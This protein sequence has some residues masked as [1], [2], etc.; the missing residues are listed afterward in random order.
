MAFLCCK[1]LQPE[2]KTIVVKDNQWRSNILRSQEQDCQWL[3]RTKYISITKKLSF[4]F[5]YEKIFI[6][7]CTV[8]I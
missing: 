7:T 3:T 6:K 8:Q 5:K 1:D 4:I 2:Y